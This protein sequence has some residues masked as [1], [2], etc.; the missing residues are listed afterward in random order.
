MHLLNFLI[1]IIVGIVDLLT[2]FLLL[3]LVT[4][5]AN[6]FTITYLED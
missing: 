3:R 2:R 6:H 4:C 5:S 1:N